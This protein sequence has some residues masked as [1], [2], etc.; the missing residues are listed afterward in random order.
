MRRLGSIALAA[1][2]I[3][4]GT[5]LV[6]WWAVPAV[7]VVWQLAEREAPPWGAALAALLGW[8]LLLALIPFAPLGRLSVRLAGVFQ[9][10]AWGLL[11]LVLGYAALM[12]WSAARVT[13]AI[14][15]VRRS[16]SRR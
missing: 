6:G 15:G 4:A 14:A 3:A 8:G 13:E 1:V 5:W 12:G 10:P 7:A 9:L 16:S 2:L 11:V